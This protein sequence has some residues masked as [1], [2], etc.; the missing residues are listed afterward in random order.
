MVEEVATINPSSSGSYSLFKVTKKGANTMDVARDMAKRLKIPPEDVSYCGLK[1]RYSISTQYMAAKGDFRFDIKARN[2]QAIYQ[3]KIDEPLKRSHLVGNKFKVVV[4][5]LEEKKAEKALEEADLV[6]EYGFPNYYD[7]QRFGS[8]RHKKGFFAMALI[9]K[10]YIEAL[11]LLLATP[12]RHD[13]KRVKR[14]KR[15]VKE[16]WGNWEKCLDLAVYP[17]EKRILRFLSGKD[18]SE[19]VAKRAI[20]LMDHEYLLLLLHAYQS[21]IWNETVKRIVEGTCQDFFRVKYS[22]G[23]MSFYRDPGDAFGKIKD[24]EIPF[25]GPKINLEGL[26]GDAMGEVLKNEG[27]ESIARFR[28]RVKGALFETH[29]RRMVVFPEDLRVEVGEDEAF[30]GKKKITVSVFLPSGSYVTVLIKRILPPSEAPRK[31]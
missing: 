16:N 22:V 15:C 8:A 20:E 7:D 17:Y 5:C 1:D 18:L 9:K 12:S 26:W 4:R 23:Y 31:M 24:L 14:F 27:I 3:G 6:K 11:K 30:E 29:R 25:P 28:T 21:F 13:E 19:K 10:K 2:Y